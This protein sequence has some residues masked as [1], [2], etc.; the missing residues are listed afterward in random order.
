[1]E[2]SSKP[3]TEARGCAG[4]DDDPV[5]ET[6]TRE[7]VE[8]VRRAGY[9]ASTMPDQATDTTNRPLIVLVHGA[10][11]GAWCWAALQSALDE[12]GA[13]SIA[14]DLPG[15]GL[16]EKSW[17]RDYSHEAQ[18]RFALSVLD[19]LH[20]ERAVLLGHSMGGNVIGW[21]L[22]LARERTGGLPFPIGIHAGWV[23]CIKAQTVFVAY[24]P[25]LN[26]ALWGSSKVFD[27]YAASMALA[28]QLLVVH[29]LT[30]RPPL[31]DA[32]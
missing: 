17:G 16:A 4:D 3:N 14:I 20:V 1:M 11:H 23:F 31:A 6:K 22:A 30:R 19:Q 32:P 28:L 24:A 25:D 5:V 9:H 15:F 29:R 10:W 21:M 18:A 27:G 7:G 26:S 12:M 8:L 2:H 13:A